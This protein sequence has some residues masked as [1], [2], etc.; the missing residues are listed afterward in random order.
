MHDLRGLLK[1][2]SGERIAQELNKLVLGQ[3]SEIVSEYADVF[4][5]FI[6]EIAACKGFD[7]RSKYHNKDVLMHTLNAVDCAPRD[8]ITRLALLLHDL[9][10]P[11]TFKLVKKAGVLRGSFK[12]HAKASTEIARR[13]LQKLKYD[14]DTRRKVLTLVRHHKTSIE[15]CP[16]VVKHLLNRFGE[17]MFF[18]LLDI[19]I[20][21]DSAK[22]ERVLK[23]LPAYQEVIE[24]AKIIIKS[25][26][27]YSLNQLAVK[28]GDLEQLGY[29]GREIGATLDFLLQAV[30]NQ[31]CGN[32]KNDLLKFAA[33]RD[34][35]TTPEEGK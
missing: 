18:K 1:G 10:K 2:V 19:H 32:N 13:T 7:Q 27:C 6:P 35:H 9:G 15:P 23:R 21:D 17:E 20:A 12:G 4:A 31:E 26:E 22:A 8:K 33:G 14:N 11:E 16:K 28:G 5:E 25:G 34:A 30:I 3:V 29:E 24:T